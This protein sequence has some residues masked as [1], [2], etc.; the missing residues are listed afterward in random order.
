MK[1]RPFQFKSAVITALL[2]AASAKVIAGGSIGKVYLPYVQPLENELEYQAIIDEQ[3]NGH[4]RYNAIHTLGVGGAISD[5]WFLEASAEYP[6]SPSLHVAA[7]ELEALWQLTEQGEYS[8]DWGLLFELE[9]NLDDDE[10]EF[11]VGV[12]NAYQLGQWQWLT[13]L[14]LIYETTKDQGNEFETALALQGKQRLKPSFEPGVE[15]FIAE[16]T[17]AIGPIIAG[18]IKA[19]RG[20]KWFWQAGFYLGGRKTPDTLVKF[21]LE[22]EF[23]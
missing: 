14:S 7:Y 16:D 19:G 18:A 9:E 23:F 3:N 11:A 10:R 21:N 5:Q 15:L 8:S 20:R 4:G 1:Q 22:Y 17:L 13:N 12:V 2:L 6:D